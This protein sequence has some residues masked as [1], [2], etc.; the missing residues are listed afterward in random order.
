MTIFSPHVIL[1]GVHHSRF[2]DEEAV[3]WTGGSQTRV[4]RVYWAVQTSL[5]S[6]V[7]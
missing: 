6:P 7:R 1:H 3:A 2:T 4:T 5:S